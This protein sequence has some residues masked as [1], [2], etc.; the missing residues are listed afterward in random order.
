MAAMDHH[1]EDTSPQPQ[2]ESSLE[3]ENQLLKNEISS[4]NQEMTSVIRRAKES[5]D[6][7]FGL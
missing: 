5:Q 2:N 6:G 4:L 7:E 1:H 3:L